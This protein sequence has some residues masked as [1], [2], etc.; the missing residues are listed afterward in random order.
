[1]RGGPGV[2]GVVGVGSSKTGSKSLVGSG[3]VGGPRSVSE[4]E[5][6]LLSLLP[7]VGDSG[8]LSESGAMVPPETRSVRSWRRVL[9]GWV[10]ERDWGK[11]MS[12][13]LICLR[14]L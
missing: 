13:R 10:T 9:P 7:L 14:I 12:L 5:L 11:V 4:P 8:S 3:G 1:L 6:L 2:D